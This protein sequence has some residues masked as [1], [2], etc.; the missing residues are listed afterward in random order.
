V[1]AA[2]A[3]DSRPR[4]SGKH[5]AWS[6]AANCQTGVEPEAYSIEVLLKSCSGG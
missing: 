1:V 5:V 3:D 4:A 6:M 2:V